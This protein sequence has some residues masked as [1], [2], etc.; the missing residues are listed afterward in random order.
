MLTAHHRTRLAAVTLG[1][2]AV[3][4]VGAP[5]ATPASTPNHAA[6][7]AISVLHERSSAKS[8]NALP[9]DFATQLGY[10]PI[11]RDGLLSAP[12]GGCSSPVPLPREFGPACRRHDLGYDLLRYADAKGEPLPPTA[13][14]TLDARLERQTR[15]ACEQRTSA[16]RRTT[17]ATW[18]SIAGGA[19]RFNSWRQHDGVPGAESPRSLLAAGGLSV[20]GLGTAALVFVGLRRT[21]GTR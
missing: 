13:R 2:A 15:A 18:S 6:S 16:V 5:A 4:V 14:R 17:C 8:G 10:Q 3:A 7:K 11:V 1:A 12:D 19:V 20:A 21:G 9:S